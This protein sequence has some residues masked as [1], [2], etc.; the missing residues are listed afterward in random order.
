ME[1]RGTVIRII[2]SND[3]NTYG[4]FLLQDYNEESIVCTIRSSVPKEGEEIS[5]YGRMV[6]HAKYGEQY[7]VSSFERLKPDDMAAAKRYLLNL[8]I[9]GLGEKSVDKILQY[10]EEDVLEILR[11]DDPQEILEVPALRQSVK[12]TLY[13]TLRGEGFLTD[14][15]A[16]LEGHG[17]SSRWSKELYEFYGASALVAIQENPYRMLDICDGMT[18]RMADGLAFKLGLEKDCPQ[19]LE[20][21]IMH[22]L[23]RIGDM[24]HT[25]L[26][27]D[28]LIEK[29][30]TLLGGQGDAIAAYIEEMLE[31]QRIYACYYEDVLYV[32]APP[33]YWAEAD[34]T[35]KTRRMC[36]PSSLTLAVE[37]FLGGFEKNNGILLGEE[38]K[39]AI[40]LAFNEQFSVITGGPGT[41][42]TTIIKAITEGFQQAGESRILL[43]A[44]TGRAAKRLTEATSYE[45]TTIHRLLMATEGDDTYNFAKNEDDPLEADVV[46]VDEASMLNVQLYHA[47]LAAIPE[48]ARVIIVGDVDQLPPIGPGFVLRDLLI[49][50]QIPYQRLTTIYRQQEGNCIV[51]N[52]YLVNDGQMPVLQGHEEFV[53][54]PVRS[55]QETLMTVAKVYQEMLA[56]YDDPLEVQII[57]PMR[58]GPMGSVALSRF[59]Q[60]R[61]LEG[62]APKTK[63]DKSQIEVKYN[64]MTYHV[65]DKV[66]QVVNNYEAEV[67]NGE[68]GVI[69]SLTNAFVGIRFSDRE[70]V[71]PIAYLEEIMP[72]YAITVHKSQGSEYG[73]V[74]IPFVPAYGG[75]LQ[76]NLLYT[77][78]T[79]ARD[80]VIMVGTVAA[81]ER[82]VVS[83]FKEERCTLFKERL[84]GEVDA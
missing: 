54:Y 4:V 20:A 46:I 68:I 24:G 78:I 30:F 1:L 8:G 12:E 72:A 9:K 29:I 74:I 36:A 70:L 17:L 33:L 37:D 62:L 79:R 73:T 25:C 2:Y 76:R 80:K 11:K 64:G 47:L 48:E 43:C 40:Q 50:E 58:R 60:Q 65:G 81:V 49:S 84:R 13:E 31:W 10:F 77:A 27:I 61:E 42:K 82:A 7:E 23:Q 14:I 45:A 63:S 55:V 5:V 44:P 35:E 51:D 71:M 83:D 18:F 28:E 56:N 52:A 26:P 22:V 53:F 67:F 66:I 21:A 41:G 34:S 75:M 15:N 57:S 3:K 19:R 32:Y 39:E 16:F 6:Q 59:V 69:I 38:Q